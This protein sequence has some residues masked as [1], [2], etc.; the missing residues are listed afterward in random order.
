MT[1]FLIQRTGCGAVLLP[2]AACLLWQ[3]AGMGSAARKKSA[4]AA[5]AAG[6]SDRAR[7]GGV[8]AAARVRNRFAIC[9]LAD[10]SPS[11]RLGFRAA[12][13]SAGCGGLA[14]GADG[15]QR[16]A[17]IQRGGRG[18]GERLARAHPNGFSREE[19]FHIA[20]RP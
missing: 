2:S 15:D 5:G 7:S 1:D 3:A 10:V 9:Y 4:L 12:R 11:D 20:T 17:Q 6:R 18:S 19:N 16:A 8:N 14:G 13:R